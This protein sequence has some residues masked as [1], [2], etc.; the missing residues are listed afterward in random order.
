LGSG[1]SQSVRGALDRI[2]AHDLIGAT[3]FVCPA[4]RDPSAFPVLISGIFSPVG[5]VPM[6][7]VQETLA[8]IE[9]DASDVR[10]GDV[11]ASDDTVQV[12]VS[13]ILRLRL[14][15]IEVEAA[16]RATAAAQGEA[17]DEEVLGQ[18]LDA[19]AAGPTS[20]DLGREVESVQVVKIG[21]GWFVCEPLPSPAP[22]P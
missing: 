5:N 18:T 16:V 15:P 21:D 19:I 17:V 1:P 13:G 4:Q 12:P 9:F 3:A 11:A 14:D 22:M 20:L 2:F 8:L 7:S 10:V 6:P